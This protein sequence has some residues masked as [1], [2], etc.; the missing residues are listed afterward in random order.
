MAHRIKPLKGN[1]PGQERGPSARQRRSTGQ[2]LI[3]DRAESIAREI[4]KTDDRAKAIGRRVTRFIDKN[5]NP[6]D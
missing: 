5:F 1:L 4:G 6:F 2:R 3:T